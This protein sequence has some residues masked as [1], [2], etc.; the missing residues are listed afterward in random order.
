MKLYERKKISHSKQPVVYK[1]FEVLPEVNHNESTAPVAAKIKNKL[2][3]DGYSLALSDL[4]EKLSQLKEQ[5]V[6]AVLKRTIERN[7]RSKLL[8]FANSEYL[9]KILRLLFGYQDMQIILQ[10]LLKTNQ[11][12]IV[13]I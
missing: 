10:R 3:E 9:K 6:Q 1:Y 7:N 12:Q 8:G 11:I 5:H 13:P 2:D 4:S